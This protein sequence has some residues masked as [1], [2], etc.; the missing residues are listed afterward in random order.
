MRHSRV[1]IYGLIAFIG[2]CTFLMYT[3]TPYA[4]DDLKY[5][6][7]FKGWMT[8]D[9]TSGYWDTVLETWS[10]KYNTDNTRI[11]NMIVPFTMVLLPKWAM[12]ILN[13][14]MVLAVY[15]GVM[16]ET[17]V[18]YSRLWLSVMLIASVTFMLPWG[19]QMLL[20]DFTLNY[21]WTSIVSLAVISLWFRCR[22]S[23]VLECCLL[24]LAGVIAGAMHEIAGLSLLCGTVAWM[25]IGRNR[26]SGGRVA[27]AAGLI[28]GLVVL[29]T[30][31]GPYLR[32][33]SS[34]VNALSFDKGWDYYVK[35]MGRCNMAS[36]LTITLIVI[37][38]TAG[39][40]AMLGRFMRGEGLLFYVASIT[41][42]VIM[43]YTEKSP[44]VSWFPQL[45][46]MMAVFVFIRDYLNHKEIS[47]RTHYTSIAII[48]VMMVVV[49]LMATVYRCRQFYIVYEDIMG[50]Y[51]ASP[52]GIVYYDVPD[53]SVDPLTLGR[54]LSQLFT[55]EWNLAVISYY[56]SGGMRR[57]VILPKSAAGV[58]ADK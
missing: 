50:L 16:R 57:L 21:V 38:F 32:A 5:L 15:L 8:G 20:C 39:G 54:P 48:L 19:D 17:H 22:R 14:L 29:L 40:R 47:N 58:P 13:T 43:F 3:Y 55:T 18:G 4:N 36:A 28:V 35:V 30:A 6:F 12:N 56:Y 34:A 46:G 23:S 26:L 25:L 53:D 33:A 31:P 7:A 41:G 27:M 1:Y 37:S 9:D 49:H 10:I 2:I 24:C 42:V 51:E 11:A 44:R 45:F 52:T